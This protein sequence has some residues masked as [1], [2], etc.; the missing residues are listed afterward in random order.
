VQDAVHVADFQH[1][2]LQNHLGVSQSNDTTQ[3]LPPT[4]RLTAS[5]V[6]SVVSNFSRTFST[7]SDAASPTISRARIFGFHVRT[8]RG[9]SAWLFPQVSPQTT[10]AKAWSKWFGRYLRAHGVHDTAKVFHSF[11][12]NFVDALRAAN[13]GEEINSA[14]VGHSDGSVS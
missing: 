1:F 13:V 4:S 7:K 10:G 12:D 8:K 6:L 11:R 5:V 14:L 2:T 3:I 9:Q